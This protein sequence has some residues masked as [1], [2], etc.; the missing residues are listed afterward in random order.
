MWVQLLTDKGLDILL[1]SLCAPLVL[2][3]ILPAVVSLTAYF[4]D[5]PNEPPL[6]NMPFDA[7]DKLKGFTHASIVK[8]PVISREPE[9]GIEI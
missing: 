7:P 3:V 2:R 1:I 8:L 4:R 9:F 5:V 6:D